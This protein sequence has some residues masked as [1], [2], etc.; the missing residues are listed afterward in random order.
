MDRREFLF[1]AGAA[2]AALAVPAAADA[3]APAPR[4]R[5]ARS[6]YVD[7]QG[8]LDGFDEPSPGKYVPSQKLIDAI[9]QRRVDIISCTIGEVGNGPDR[10]RGAAEAVA[11]WDRLIAEHKNLLAK[12]ESAAD[13]RAAR[14]AGKLGLIYNFQDTTALEAD[15]GKV[16]TFATLGVKV[17]QL[18]YN[19]RNLAG[20]GCL[21][22][23]NAG[24]SDFGREVIAKIEEA[25]VLLDLSHAGQRTIAEAIAA[26]K[27]PPAITHSGCRA[28]VDLPRNVGDAEMRALAN[29]GGVF[30]VYLMPFL[31]IKG[32]AGTEDL[33]RH[34]DHAV[35]V[36]GEDHVGI[37]TDNPL[38]GYTIDDK[39]RQQQR[40][41]F[42]DRRK[43]GIAAPGEAADIFNL[44]EG[45][46]DVARYDRIGADLRRR[47]WSS[48]RVDKV[49]G[50]NFVRL[51]G[52]VWT[53]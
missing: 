19:K 46:N 24:L 51:F 47:G 17:I 50:D 26:S 1:A 22:R 38:M 9:R 4:P 11:N 48:A 14:A 27:A 18:T 31:R 23:S 53:A 52:E 43:K 34:L 49:L 40:E 29:K 12:I 5:K 7:A 45:Y 21:E 8:A 3:Q 10:F 35:K 30:G 16:A 6:I 13:I 44:V 20:D 15:A 37:G 25:R 41:F 2:G 32:Q 36:C 33:L 39:A 28:L 42:E